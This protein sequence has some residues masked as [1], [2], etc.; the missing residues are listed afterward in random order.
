MERIN[1]TNQ[2]RTD[3]INF[4][5]D[6]IRNNDVVEV[7]K[8]KCRVNHLAG[9]EI[10]KVSAYDEA[11]YNIEIATT[12]ED[13]EHWIVMAEIE[14]RAIHAREYEKRRDERRK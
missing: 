3:Q 8:A 13:R 2:E 5:T 11:K 7:E 6:A 1:I 10:Y 14:C 4:L 12:Q 9:L